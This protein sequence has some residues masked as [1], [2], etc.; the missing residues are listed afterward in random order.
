MEHGRRPDDGG[1]EGHGGDRPGGHGDDVHDPRRLPAGRLH[2][3]HRRPVLQVVRADDGV[4]GGDVA[5]RRVH[6]RSDAVVAVRPVHPA[7]RA[8]AHADGTAVRAHGAA[9]TT[10]SIARYHRVLALGA[11]HPWKSLGVAA[12]V[13]SSPACRASTIIGTEFVPRRG[14]RRVP[15]H[16]RA[17]ARH[18]VRRERPA[19]VAEVERELL[20]DARSHAR[21]SA[22]SASNGQ[23]RKS[24][25]P[26]ADVTQKTS[27]SAGSAR[28]R[29]RSART[30]AAMPFVEA[31]SRDPEFMQGAPYEPPIN[32]F[33]RGDDLA[34]LQRI[35]DDIVARRS[36]RFPAPSTSAARSCR[37]AGGGRAGQSFAAPPTSASASAASRRSCA[38]WSRVSCRAGCATATAST[39]SAY[40]WRPSIRNDFG[41]AAAGAALLADRRGRAHG[42][43]RGSRRPSGRASIDR[44]QRRRQAKIG[45]DLART[46]RSA[47][48][49]PTS[50]PR[51]RTSSCRRP[52]SGASPATSS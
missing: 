24:H 50:Q 35:S 34:E 9:R 42:R 14:S 22:R 5:A 21:C 16:R 40:A 3:G 52:S 2:D 20:D 48:S 29:T 43:R 33:V 37:P 46:A 36:A 49:R 39:T 47:T 27:A 6:A 38:A 4:R 30:L 17:A 26:R 1:A 28:S 7:R 51:S 41:G 15:G 13:S 31:R 23:I 18:V 8:D 11:R 12:A 10:G 19:S 44:E 25:A 32:V 45:V